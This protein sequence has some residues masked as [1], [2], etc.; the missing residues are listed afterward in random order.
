MEAGLTN[1]LRLLFDID[2]ETKDFRLSTEEYVRLKAIKKTEES[3]QIKTFFI[4]H[5]NEIETVIAK[6]KYI[7]N[8]YVG[9]STCRGQ[10]ETEEYMWN[11][12]VVALDYDRKDYPQYE[13]IKDFSE[14]IKRKI[15]Y[16]FYH[17]IVDS[18]NG[19]HFY[20][21]TEPTNNIGQI[22]DINKQLVELL[23][24]DPRA[25]S[26]T[27]LMRLPTSLNVKHESK[28]VNI[29]TNN[30]TSEKFRP[31]PLNKLDKIIS[32]V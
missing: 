22:T 25:A 24:A 7:T 31:Y 19:Y 6:Y 4:K 14:H 9:L 29:V 12:R 21:A 23:G 10:N 16:L 15:P 18:G 32:F 17:C 8:L 20:I 30:I 11:R 5:V 26:P 3:T 28:L 1:F 27:Q 13:T 2:P